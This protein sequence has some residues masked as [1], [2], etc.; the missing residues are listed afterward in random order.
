MP[1]QLKMVIKK[2]FMRHF[3]ILTLAII[4]CAMQSDDLYAFGIKIEKTVNDVAENTY[5]DPQVQLCYITYFEWFDGDKLGYRSQCRNL[6]APGECTAFDGAIR[7]CARVL[8]DTGPIPKRKIC[9]YQDP[10]DL[11]ATLGFS[12]ALGET[13]PHMDFMPFQHNTLLNDSSVLEGVFI[14]PQAGMAYI[15]GRGFKYKNPMQM[16][17]IMNMVS[18]DKNSFEDKCIYM[19]DGPYPPPFCATL[20]PPKQAPQIWPVCKV[21]ETPNIN[22]VCVRSATIQSSFEKPAVRVQFPNL[23]SK[24]SVGN[25]SACAQFINVPPNTTSDTVLMCNTSTDTGPCVYVP[26]S[27]LAGQQVRLYY[28]AFM[29]QRPDPDHQGVPWFFSNNLNVVV[30]GVDTGN[31][32]DFDLD[33][34][35]L[36]PSPTGSV[37][38]STPKAVPENTTN[39]TRSFTIDFDSIHMD[40]ITVSEGSTKWQTLKRPLPSLPRVAKCNQQLCTNDDCS[41][42]EIV[43]CSSSNT[44][45]RMAISFG[46]PSKIITLGAND[47]EKSIYV[48]GYQLSTFITDDNN[49]NPLENPNF[50][51]QA[52][53][54]VVGYGITYD[55]VSGKYVYK[56]GGKKMCLKFYNDHYLLVK[57]V[58]DYTGVNIVPSTKPADVLVPLYPLDPMTNNPYMI[59]VLKQYSDSANGRDP[60]AGEMI[61]LKV[62]AELGL[63]IPIMAKCSGVLP[64]VTLAN[65]FGYE[66]YLS[67]FV[68][69][70]TCPQ[71]KEEGETCNYSST[72]TK[73]VPKTDITH[74]AT[75]NIDYTCQADGTF[76]SP[77]VNGVTL[78]E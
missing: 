49:Q 41:T 5:F 32:S 28:N 35:G 72:V 25:T 31:Y 15:A 20:A 75:W 51:D 78:T 55:V 1:N 8:V 26:N 13:D 23:I 77:V 58:A 24:C 46:N 68:T 16:Q 6:H 10:Y 57:G 42:N 66:L 18:N 54:K 33:L 45:P 52:T 53:S 61:R 67:D 50:Y 65:Y 7:F 22:N 4:I 34:T 11:L 2:N 9:V 64:D 76:G 60:A 19:K 37:V 62:A 38:A 63:C 47:P 29:G 56:G 27:P 14:D 40:E 43:S 70:P 39:V 21:G 17:T 48:Y 12:G 44:L 74:T 30:G 59:G 73:F 36:N 71:E 3:F 69:N